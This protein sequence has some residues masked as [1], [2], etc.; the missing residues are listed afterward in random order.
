MF[1]VMK[2]IF[3]KQKYDQAKLKELEATLTNLQVL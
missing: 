2:E 3:E 1:G